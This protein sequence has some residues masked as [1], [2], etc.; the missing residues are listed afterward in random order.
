[1]RTFFLSLLFIVPIQLMAQD[2]YD[3][4]SSGKY[5]MN[6]YNSGKYSFAIME[7]ERLLFLDSTNEEV[8][9]LLANSHKMNNSLETGIIRSEQLY[10]GD[11]SLF[12][13]PFA[14]NYAQMLI[15]SGS[16]EKFSFSIDK[17]K[18]DK[19]IKTRYILDCLMLS[20]KWLEAS[21]LNNE[22]IWGESANEIRRAEL[23]AKG[24]NPELKSRTI[25][26]FLSTIIP[27]MGKVYTKN[28][29]DGVFT[30]LLVTG[31]AYQSYRAFS[32]NGIQSPMG[33]IFGGLSLGFYSGNIFGSY[34]AA[35]VYNNN[36]WKNLNEETKDYIFSN[37]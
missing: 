30:F 22:T 20:Q 25:S 21:K 31:S 8:R 23:I 1:M 35:Q 36:Y 32:G 13:Q 5:A 7:F 10:H 33:W 24:N 16:Y 18:L 26:L 34:R 17:L 12:P 37:Y 27:G 4:K 6:L 28:Y 3:L 14:E 29:V 19:I 15:L 2:L 11:I 9:Y